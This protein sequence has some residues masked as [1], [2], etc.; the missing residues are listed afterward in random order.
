MGIAQHTPSVLPSG[1]SRLTPAVHSRYNAQNDR[2]VICSLASRWDP[3]VYRGTHAA[4]QLHEAFH[5]PQLSEI[6]PASS[7]GFPIVAD[8]FSI[9]TEPQ[10]ED[11]VLG[12]PNT[13]P[14]VAYEWTYGSCLQPEMDQG[15]TI[16]R[17]LVAY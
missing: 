13:H 6:T 14:E 9:Q 12:N 10:I 2:E 5:A 1:L 8:P 7:Q 11:R 17:R 3:K 4:R 15:L 16:E